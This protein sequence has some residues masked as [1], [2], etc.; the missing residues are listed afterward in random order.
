MTNFSTLTWGGERRGGN[1]TVEDVYAASSK[2]QKFS[3]I[4]KRNAPKAGRVV[5]NKDLKEKKAMERAEVSLEEL[6]PSDM[7]Q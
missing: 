1:F 6:C 5:R 4:W 2:I 7:Q 3:N